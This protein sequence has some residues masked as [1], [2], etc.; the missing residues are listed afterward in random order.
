MK[1]QFIDRVLRER[2]VDTAKY[3]YIVKEYPDR[4]EIQRLPI[5]DLDT[6]ASIDGWETVSV[7]R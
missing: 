7:I 2:I 4:A 6:T 1:K 5:T 3:R